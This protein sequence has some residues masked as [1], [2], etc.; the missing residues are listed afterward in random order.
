L[1]A[2][3]KLLP[4]A[5]RYGK[6]ALSQ[7][8]DLPCVPAVCVS[9]PCQ[10]RY[11]CQEPLLASRCRLTPAIGTENQTIDGYRTEAVAKRPVQTTA[12]PD[13]SIMMTRRA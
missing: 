3:E 7:Q 9:R 6:L 5:R 2:R 4:F 13:G 12:A 1:S 8:I 11:L 10:A